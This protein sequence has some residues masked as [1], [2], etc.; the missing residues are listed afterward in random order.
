MDSAVGSIEEDTII[1][2]GVEDSI[3]NQS[4]FSKR[5]TFSA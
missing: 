1:L 4:F 2:D 5:D 3:N